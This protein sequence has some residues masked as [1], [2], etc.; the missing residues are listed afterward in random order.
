[1][2]P[3]DF[4]RLAAIVDALAAGGPEAAA[5]EVVRMALDL[6]RLY[7]GNF[8]EGEEAAWAIA[9]RERLRSKF[10]RSAAALGG[11]LEGAGGFEQAEVH[12]RRALEVDP[13]AEAFYCRLMRCLRAQGRVAEALEAYRRCRDLLSITLGVQPSPHTQLIG[14]ALQG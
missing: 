6:F 2:D 4:E 5:D 7:P 12:Y 13:L 8:L 3:W 10:L 9:Q 11:R 14:L 1:M